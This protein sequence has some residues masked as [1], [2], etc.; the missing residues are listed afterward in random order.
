[1]LAE[2]ESG[3]P[4]VEVKTNVEVKAEPVP[5]TVP[6][7]SLAD[8]AKKSKIMS[9]LI[10]TWNVSNVKANWSGKWTFSKDGVVTCN[11]GSKGQWTIDDKQVLIEWGLGK[12]WDSLILPLTRSAKGDSSVGGKNA[13][14]AVRE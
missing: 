5:A 9:V 4:K 2:L 12:S 10:G 6:G 1:M 8:E 7:P 13:L 14:K 11:N 3:L